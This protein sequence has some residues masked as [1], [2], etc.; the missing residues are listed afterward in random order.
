[1]SEVDAVNAKFGKDTVRYG[2]LNPAGDWQTKF[3]KR[4]RCYTTRPCDV[5]R[6]A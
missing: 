6:G 2:A 1:M 4:S 5:L 3:M